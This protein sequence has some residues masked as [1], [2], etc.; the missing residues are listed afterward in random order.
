MARA[1]HDLG[2]GTS[3][4]LKVALT[5]TAP[6]ATDAVLADID[7]LAA[8]NGYPAGGLS[9]GTVTGTETGGI[10]KLALGTDPLFV[11]SGGAMGPFRYAVL[12]NSTPAGGPLIAW[13]DYGF[14]TTLNPGD[15]FPVDLNQGDGVFTIA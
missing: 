3:H 10:F 9:A 4:V 8:G 11:A 2:T 13:F 1:K 15:E 12:Y 14:A 6:Q 5:A 7:E